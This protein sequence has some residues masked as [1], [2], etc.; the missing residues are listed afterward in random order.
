LYKETLI[1]TIMIATK[2]WLE[3]LKNKD[4]ARAMRI[5]GELDD[6]NVQ[7]RILNEIEKETTR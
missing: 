3:A 5:R 1:N 4:M 6:L 7:L 2:H